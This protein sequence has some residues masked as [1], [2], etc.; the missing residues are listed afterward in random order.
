MIFLGLLVCINVVSANE[1]NSTSFI[2][3]EENNISKLEDSFII[4]HETEISHNAGEKFNISLFDSNNKP[5]INQ[6][7]IIS[8]NG[9]N[10]TK[11]TD[12]NG[13]AGLTINLNIGKYTVQYY[14]NGNENY[15]PSKGETILNVIPNELKMIGDDLTMDYG[16]GNYFKIQLKDKN[17]NNI[18]NEKVIMTINGI[19][20]TKITDENG[21]ASLKINLFKGIYQILYRLDENS[22]YKSNNNSKHVYVYGTAHLTSSELNMGHKSKQSFE[23]KVYDSLNRL[24]KDVNVTIKIN[25]ENYIKTTNNEGIAKLT[26]NLNPG[27]YF[28]EYNFGTI[29]GYNNVNVRSSELIGKN[30]QINYG[31]GEYFEVALKDNNGNYL[32]GKEV[33]LTINGV[34][35]V[36]TTD[37]NGMIY[38][39]INLNVGEY[40]I[41][42]NYEGDNEYSS[43]SVTNIITVTKAN[44]IVA[45]GK[46]SCIHCSHPYKKYTTVF[47]N[48]CPVCKKEGT[49]TINPKGVYEGEITCGSG[50]SS[51]NYGGGCDA[52]YCIVCGFEKS[53][54]NK[55]K[56]TKA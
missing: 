27:N 48:Y 18:S 30:T 54:N 4:E 55:H 16:S 46:P 40:T 35:Y 11:T 21:I 28:V 8:V 31:K 37:S 6:L 25:G 56:L 38:L 5:I 20:Y 53:Y 49:L 15:S 7:V 32:Q 47:I 13:I 51:N 26:I 1:D 22:R 34:T 41:T 19:D 9:V 45:T 44:T 2:L 23:I 39:K 24:M 33:S 43:S 42:C 36:K 14:F 52:D 17:N 29:Y 10:Y 50:T 3:S 12:E